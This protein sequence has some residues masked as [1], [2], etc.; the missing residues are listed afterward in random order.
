MCT[1]APKPMQ[2][3]TDKNL[4]NLLRYLVEKW[5]D[6]PAYTDVQAIEWSPEIPKEVRCPKGCEL[7]IYEGGT[8]WGRIP[9]HDAYRQTRRCREH[10]Y[11]RI[12]VISGPAAAAH[13]VPLNK[14]EAS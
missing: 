1:H 11:A 7:K 12:Y 9:D 13:N 2:N 5:S 8:G 14:E 3:Q 4:D 6:S 10:G